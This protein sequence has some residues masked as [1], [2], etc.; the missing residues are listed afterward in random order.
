MAVPE[1][2]EVAELV[3]AGG[4]WSGVLFD[5]PS[6]GFGPALHWEFTFEFQEIRRDYGDTG[7]HLS[8]D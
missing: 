5:N 8:I 2:L 4:S 3:P 7:C 6:I 1:D